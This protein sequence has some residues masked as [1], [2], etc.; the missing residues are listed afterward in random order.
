MD[1]IRSAI[2]IL[3]Y[4]KEPDL[5]L[6]EFEDLKKLND[7]K[8][9][10]LP[11]DIVNKNDFKQKYTCG[12][13]T[14]NQADQ[15]YNILIN[16]W[17]LGKDNLI[18]IFN[19]LIEFG[20]NVLR[21]KDGN[22][23]CKYDDFF[24]WHEMTSLIGED[25]L[26]CSFLANEEKNDV[27][28]RKKFAWKLVLESDNTQLNNFFCRGLSELHCHLNASSINFDAN[29]LAIMNEPKHQKENWF[30]E[31]ND[32]QLYKHALLAAY[33]RMYLF[34]SINDINDSNLFLKQF[35]MIWSANDKLSLVEFYLNDLQSEIATQSSLRGHVFENKSIDYAVP[36]SLSRQDEKTIVERFLVGERK[37]MY[38][39]F[40]S[41]F[42][43]NTT[44][45]PSIF[46][47]YLIVKCNV[48][49]LLVQHNKIKGFENFT[50]FDKNK[51]KFVKNA[52]N[53]AYN[54]LIPKAT[55]QSYQNDPNIDYYEFRIAPEKN[56]FSIR[57]ELNNH[58][59]YLKKEP[60]L[61][62][63]VNN[64][65]GLYDRFEKEIPH[66][67]LHFIKKPDP[68]KYFEDNFLN[69]QICRNS[70]GRKQYAKEALAIETLLKRNEKR[71][72]GIDAANSEFGCRPEVFA[73]VFRQL[74]HIN[75]DTSLDMIIDNECDDLGITYH[76]GEDYYDVVDGLRAI[77][78]A[79]LFLNL[80]DGS[81][82]GHAVALGIDVVKYYKERKNNIII[83]KQDLLDNCVWL[84]HKMDE[85]GIQD[86]TGARDK[87]LFLFQRLA[88][89]LY[90][91]Y[92]LKDYHV[93]YLSWLLRGD[94][95]YLYQSNLC[96]PPKDSFD[97]YDLNHFDIQINLA[98]DN[99]EAR[100]LYNAY[101]FDPKSKH[102]GRQ[103]EEI[104]LSN[105]I[106]EIIN[107]IQVEMRKDIA[108][109]KIAIEVNPTSNLRICNIDTYDTHPILK[110]RNY[111]LSGIDDANDCPQISV[112]I[113]TDDKGI[114]ATSLE[115]EYTLMALAVEKM[116]T[117]DG[118]P[119]YQPNNIL[120]WLE[121]IRQEAFTQRF[122]KTWHNDLTKRKQ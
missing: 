41:I 40:Q 23:I 105:G 16:S 47:Y 75:R 26:T 48:K 54:E 56:A 25:I 42:Y 55:I 5:V 3:F 45:L 13:Y 66:C 67:V 61:C 7:Y 120:V 101:H 60:S 116:K 57:K 21:L 113:N 110:F 97:K 39:C 33:I 10:I 95:P 49:K 94:D 15:L 36:I 9:N 104:S 53:S 106:V 8:K 77:E 83:P 52:H 27:Y 59:N 76:V 108:H 91:N 6:K 28:E 112:S 117:E 70:D 51:K 89:E 90:P 78:E 18:S 98:R 102:K 121:G 38:Q 35:E 44:E 82:L 85:Y 43:R 103:S 69:S 19:V 22:P 24:R 100:E 37:L 11:I 92:K 20:K 96:E 72:V 29:W 62:L 115:K 73:I 63:N 114:F 50:Y 81:R 34:I 68:D 74:Q 86:R 71:I 65:K 99:E 46:Y 109:R 79:I 58:S 64:D 118:K 4:Q 119:K 80:I 84:L 93:Y 31:F 111:G 17:M 30:N 122:V 88:N 14:G 107:E 87:L 32:N 1:N 2:E 12:P